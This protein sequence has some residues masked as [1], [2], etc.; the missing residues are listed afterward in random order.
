MGRQRSLILENKAA[1]LESETQRYELLTEINDLRRQIDIWRKLPSSDWRVTPETARLLWHWR[2]YEF[3]GIRPFFCQV[4]AVETVIWLTEVAPTMGRV[5]QRFLDHLR[6]ANNAANLGLPRLALK[7]ATGV[8]KTAV[9]AMLIAWQTVNASR[10]PNSKHFTKDFLV[11]TPG[12][13]TRD[14]LRVLHPTDPDNY[15]KSRELIPNDMLRVLDRLRIVIS[16]FQAFKPRATL[17]T[18]KAGQSPLPYEESRNETLELEEQM[19]RSVMPELM[20]MNNIFVFNCEAHYCY[21]ENT[22]KNEEWDLKGETKR[23]AAKNTERARLWI[24]GLEAV[25]R[26]VGVCQAID[27]SATPFFSHGSGYAEGTLF[28]WTM[29]D[30][31]LMDAIES[32]IVKIPRIPR[33]DII[34]NAGAPKFRYLWDHIS[35]KMPK[36]SLSRSASLDP[37]SIPNE[38]QTALTALYG[39]YE[40]TFALWEEFAAEAPPC[41]VVVCDNNATSKLVYD[42]ISGFHCTNEDGSIRFCEGR[43]PLF[44][45]YDECGNPYGR[46]RTILIDCEQFESG[47]ALERNFRSAAADEIERFRKGIV[48][49]PG[50]RTQAANWSDQDLLREAMRT[51]GAP[52]GLGGATRCVVSVAMLAEGWDMNTVTHVLGLRSF[53]TQLLCEQ[54][55]GRS[56]RRRCYQ[57]NESGVFDPEFAHVLGIPFDFAAQPVFTPPLPPLDR[58]LVRAISP[59]RNKCEITFPRVV[60]YREG[61]LGERLVARFD[62]NSNLELN[63]SVVES[64]VNQNGSVIGEGV[65]IDLQHLEETGRC[66]I[67]YYLAAQLLDRHWPDSSGAL[68]LDLFGQLKEI[69]HD[70]MDHHL[71]CSNGAYPAQLLYQQLADRAC[72]RIKRAITKDPLGKRLPKI[73]LDPRNPMG[74]TSQVH[75]HA[76]RSPFAEGLRAGKSLWKT[77]PRMCHVNLVACDSSW[78]AEFCRVAENRHQ[79]RAYVKNQGLGF[80]VPYR[81]RSESRTYMPDFILLLDDG[82]GEDDLLRVVVEL[83]GFRRESV[84]EKASAMQDYWIP[85][86]NSLGTFGRWTFLE[87]GSAFQM[88]DGFE[89]RASISVQ[90]T[91][92]VNHILRHVSAEAARRLALIGGTQPDAE[93]IPRRRSEIC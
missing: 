15:Y 25:R 10:R 3:R 80:G 67:V 20:S 31:S 19:L 91:N 54:V 2:Y 40:K 68:K 92:A 7:L 64:A 13:T 14:R 30:F 35:E 43:L 65:D 44:R 50:D 73:T 75:F 66:P 16:N 60:G 76:G 23:E 33:T 46:P 48:E 24:S 11:V 57:L 74:S 63:P 45:N 84:K 26:K 1:Q 69:V 83:N 61:V 77:C 9:M 53:G 32:G 62:M 58:V 47:E 39:H 22:G 29:S 17:E 52:G 79:V 55:V 71:K 5:G 21:R 89:S 70:W 49:R 8:G 85:G 82:N 34:P 78:E 93:Y 90:F 6:N 36:K 28:P 56:L 41:F 86:V 38:L 81:F 37:L 72:R 88:E 87:L 18:S 27:L 59:D 4:E 12:L 42:Y 51:V